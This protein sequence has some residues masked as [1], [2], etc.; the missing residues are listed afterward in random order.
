M[1]HAPILSFTSK[2]VLTFSSRLDQPIVITQ[3]LN[4]ICMV[5]LG[6][7]ISS[8]QILITTNQPFQ[9]GVCMV[10]QPHTGVVKDGELY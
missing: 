9:V 5:S 4:D 1:N 6:V 2:E 8:S 10:M 7:V 3:T